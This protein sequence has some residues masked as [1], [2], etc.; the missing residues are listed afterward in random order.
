MTTWTKERIHKL[1]DSNSK[2]VER[3]IVAIYKRQTGD[4]M[5]GH[6]TRHT[7]GVGFSQYDASFLSSLAE[8]VIK[9][10]WLSDRQLA[11]GRNKIKRYHRQLCE[12]ANERDESQQRQIEAVTPALIPVVRDEFDDGEYGSWGRVDESEFT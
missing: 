5:A 12:L 6:T 8:Q 1:L 10:R 4:E 11:V 3:A 2:A 7:N 9:G